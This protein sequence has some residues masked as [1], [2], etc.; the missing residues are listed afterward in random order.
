ML[1]VNFFELNSE[2]YKLL[3]LSNFSTLM[4]LG[5]AVGHH[6]KIQ[7]KLLFLESNEMY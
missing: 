3:F 1:S 6:N 5:N 7:Q 2:N 4:K